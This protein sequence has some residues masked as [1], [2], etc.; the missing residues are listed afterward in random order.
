MKCV[1]IRF[2]AAQVDAIA[3][4]AEIHDPVCTAPVI[5]MKYISAGAAN[6]MITATP[7]AKII[8]A[9]PA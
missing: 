9:A 7:T 2:K 6:Q 8:R 1:G 4:C 3:R 5:E